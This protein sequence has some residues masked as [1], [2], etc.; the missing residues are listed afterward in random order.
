MMSADSF[1]GMSKKLGQDTAEAK[2][3]IF[4]LIRIDDARFL[5]YPEDNRPDRVCVEIDNGRITKAKIQ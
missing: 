3:M 1:L 4:R 5:D 2:N